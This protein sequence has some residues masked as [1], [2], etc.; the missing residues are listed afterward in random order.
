MNCQNL[1]ASEQIEND[2]DSEKKFWTHMTSE[3]GVI[4]LVR[5]FFFKKIL[6]VV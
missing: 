1:I 6:F 3:I 5:I 2:A 4:L